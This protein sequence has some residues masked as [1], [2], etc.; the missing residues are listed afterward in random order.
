MQ[1]QRWFQDRIAFVNPMAFH[2]RML[3]L[4]MARARFELAKYH[5]LNRLPHTL[6]WLQYPTYSHRRIDARRFVGAEASDN[7]H[8]VTNVT[9]AILAVLSGANHLDRDPVFKSNSEIVDLTH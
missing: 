9:S 5:A 2:K 4:L 7:L 1:L 6:S 3:S 8:F